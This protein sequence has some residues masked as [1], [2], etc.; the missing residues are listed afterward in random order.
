MTKYM[1]IRRQKNPEYITNILNDHMYK[2]YSYE[3]Y[4]MIT[5]TKDMHIKNSHP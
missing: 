3:I 1:E 2:K 5:C 4:F